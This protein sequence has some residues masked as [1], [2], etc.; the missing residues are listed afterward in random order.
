[1]GT[2]IFPSVNVFLQVAPS[3]ISI[4]RH[5]PGCSSLHILQMELGLS[6]CLS[7]LQDATMLLSASM[8]LY[9]MTS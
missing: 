6:P 8:A 1:M 5:T 3:I 9:E 7:I 4:A 2:H